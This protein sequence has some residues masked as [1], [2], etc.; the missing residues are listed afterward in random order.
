MKETM[1]E[2]QRMVR[3]EAIKNI[4]YLKLIGEQISFNEKNLMSIFDHPHYLEAHILM[5]HAISAAKQVIGTKEGQMS[6]MQNLR[7]DEYDRYLKSELVTKNVHNIPHIDR[8]IVANPTFD[9]FQ[10]ARLYGQI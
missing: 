2:K 5:K 9:G 8:L 10:I 7:W 1:T 3:F 6:K 4:V